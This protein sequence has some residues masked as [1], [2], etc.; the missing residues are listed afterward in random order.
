MHE[1]TLQH[2]SEGLVVRAVSDGVRV[3]ACF[4]RPLEYVPFE[5]SA[6]LSTDTMARLL[7]TATNEQKVRLELNDTEV[8]FEMYTEQRTTRYLV[9]TIDCESVGECKELERLC[10]LTLRTEHMRTLLKDLRFAG[11]RLV[12]EIENGALLLVGQADNA[13]GEVVTT[14]VHIDG[15]EGSYGVY[16]AGVMSHFLKAQH[17]SNNLTI[18]LYGSRM[19]MMLESDLRLMLELDELGGHL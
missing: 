3:E 19:R 9:P 10:V 1:V 7:R 4:L 11:D 2:G 8:R 16:S 14:E 15:A 18:H 17:V 5:K 12:I 6:V 13:H